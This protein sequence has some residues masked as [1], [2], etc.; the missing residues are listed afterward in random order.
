MVRIVDNI[1]DD[2]W[3]K[4]YNHH[5]IWQVLE[6]KKSYVVRSKSNKMI[7]SGYNKLTL[8]IKTGSVRTGGNRY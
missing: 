5:K 6:Q 3:K 8:S 1:L 4:V 7:Q 2:E